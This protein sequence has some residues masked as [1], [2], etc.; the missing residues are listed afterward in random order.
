MD[1]NF[2]DLELGVPFMDAEHRQLAQLFDL[3][4]RCFHDGTVAERAQSVVDEALSL[5]SA[6]FEHEEAEMERMRYPQTEQHKFIH[7]NMRLQFGALMAD[8]IAHAQALDPVTLE[9]LDLIRLRIKEH[10]LGADADFAAHCLAC[11]A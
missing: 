9:H 10:I 5:V 7:R 6:H 3:F 1:S 2:A 8:T 11:Y 4:E